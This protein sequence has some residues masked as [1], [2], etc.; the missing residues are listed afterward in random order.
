MTSKT[1]GYITRAKAE[2]ISKSL[3]FNPVTAIIGPRQ[4][5][6]STLARH[7]LENR[8]DVVN[9]DLDLPSDNRKLDDAEFFLNEHA[10]QLVCIDEVQ[11]KP[12]LFPLLRALVDRDRRPGRFLVL[13]SVGRDLLR[14]GGQTLAGRIHYVELTPF[15]WSEVEPTSTAKGDSFLRHWWRGGFP[16]SFLVDDEAAS[17]VWRQDLIQDYLYRDIPNFGYTIPVATIRRFWTMLAHYHGGLFNASKIG[18]ALDASNN[19]IRKYLDILDQTFMVRVLRPLEINVRKRLVKSPKVYLRDSGLLHSLLEIETSTALHGNPVYG[20]SW[21]GWC[22]EQICGALP[23]WRAAFYRTSSGEEIDLVLERGDTRLAFECKAS[24]S[25]HV[26]RG[27]PATLELLAP[28]RT[29]IVCPMTGPS[30]THRTGARITGMSECL[31]DL[32]AY[33]K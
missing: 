13:G 14:Q 23:A 3:E 10:E 7:L 20:A 9:L 21:E 16:D 17:S 24:I 25:P 28:E 22:I 30:Y 31:R 29:W 5:G 19:T 1:Q 18:Q 6:K 32:S 15:L 8:A 11:E 2:E 26:S 12:G 33:A 27:F 4:C